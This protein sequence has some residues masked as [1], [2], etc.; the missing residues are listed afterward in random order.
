MC[1]TRVIAGSSRTDAP[2]CP[3][4]KSHRPNGFPCPSLSYGSDPSATLFPKLKPTT[5]KIEHLSVTLPLMLRHLS[6]C[7]ESQCI[8]EQLEVQDNGQICHVYEQPEDLSP[9]VNVLL[10]CE[11]QV[12]LQA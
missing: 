4:V 2:R 10:H 12:Q 7:G 1:S 11:V 9:L 8:S 5:L 6:T 3:H